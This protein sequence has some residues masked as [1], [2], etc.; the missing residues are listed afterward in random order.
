MKDPH[1]HKKVDLK[2]VLRS[3][4]FTYIQLEAVTTP[5]NP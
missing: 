1:S 3:D 2:V 5:Y 4:P